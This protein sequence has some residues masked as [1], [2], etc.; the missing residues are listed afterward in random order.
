MANTSSWSY[1][2]NGFG[3]WFTRIPYDFFATVDFLVKLSTV[4]DFI[5][6][7]HPRLVAVNLAGVLR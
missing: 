1:A 5:D 2:D 6:R 7:T 4:L 3:K